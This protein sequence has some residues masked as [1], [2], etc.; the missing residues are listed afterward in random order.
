[1]KEEHYTYQ[2][3][4]RYLKN[5]LSLKESA[6]FEKRLHSDHAFAEAV[7]LQKLTN[8]L[9][10]EERFFR[11]MSE[12]DKPSTG[13]DLKKG[14][15]LGGVALFLISGIYFITRNTD[16]TRENNKSHII[17]N[18]E[19][20]FGK[21]EQILSNQETGKK[22]IKAKEKKAGEEIIYVHADTNST[23]SPQENV[24]K[25]P[26]PALKEEEEDKPIVPFK[27]DK[28]GNV[29]INAETA[30]HESC[31][32]DSTGMIEIL[33]ST[34]KG[35]KEPYVFS[36]NEEYQSANIFEHLLPGKYD[37][38]I[39][40]N[41]GCIS[42]KKDITV[43]T[44]PCVKSESFSFNPY[45]GELW[46]FPS[47]DYQNFKVRITSKEGIEVY[48]MEINGG[49]PAEW[50]GTSSE[51]TALPS[52]TYFYVIEFSDGKTNQGYIS[53]IE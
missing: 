22:V 26:D 13:S 27:E 25:T 42:L 16:K 31:A 2:L 21:E 48:R 52:G 10:V 30:A 9:I 28:C 6:D 44:K 8:E 14:I 33:L 11:I 18:N 12:I 41:N 36:L 45:Y 38:K 5:E 32:G 43:K 17:T 19:H 34:L 1:M 20:V 50:N 46:K 24:V 51:G 53:I 7:N 35:G 4:D 47:G 37:L 29:L 15:I 49:S 40:D 39:K 23:V 3:I